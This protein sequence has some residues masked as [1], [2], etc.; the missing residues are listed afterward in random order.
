MAI[1]PVLSVLSNLPWGTIVESAP[2]VAENASRLWETVKKRRGARTDPGD[3]APGVPATD[4]RPADLLQ[5]QAQV[6]E[7]RSSV[8][9]LE[10]EL[11]HSAGVIR[12]LADQNARLIERVEQGRR[13]LKRVLV[14][15]SVWLTLLSVVAVTHLGH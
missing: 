15:G 6:G 5:L 14:L 4:P 12:D 7:L 10:E 8:T 3:E 9:S 1:G 11:R 2:K 13:T